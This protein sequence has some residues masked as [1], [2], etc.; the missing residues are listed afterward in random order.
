MSLKYRTQKD[1]VTQLQKISLGITPEKVSNGRV[2]M[3]KMT[4]FR[5]AQVFLNKRF[6][7]RERTL[8]TEWN[9]A[10]E[11]LLPLCVRVNVCWREQKRDWKRIKMKWREQKRDWKVRGATLKQPG[12]PD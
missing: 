10:D 1:R 11:K 9:D 8:Y 5:S 2:L 12:I 4:Q 7:S 6:R 3:T